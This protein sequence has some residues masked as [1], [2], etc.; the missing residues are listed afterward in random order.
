MTF[1]IYH[2][3]LSFSF[4]LT[5][6]TNQAQ[7]STLTALDRES[8]DSYHMIVT[9]RDNG[10]IPLSNTADVFVTVL[11]VNDHPP[12]FDVPGYSLDLV[13]ETTYSSCLTVHVRNI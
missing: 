10:P 3:S 1:I 8:I 12:V 7:L 4:Q 5:S 9:V 13:E 6:F 11:D 2:K